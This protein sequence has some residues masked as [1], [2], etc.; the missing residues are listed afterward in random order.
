MPA[1]NKTYD[2]KTFPQLVELAREEGKSTDH[3]IAVWII[4]HTTY[5]KSQ[6]YQKILEELKKS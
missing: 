3:E 5:W 1:K 4:N 2:L 6:G